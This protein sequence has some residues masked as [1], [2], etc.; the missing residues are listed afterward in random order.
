MSFATAGIAPNPADTPAD[1]TVVET[2]PL[3]FGLGE[4]TKTITLNIDNDT[5]YELTESLEVT[6]TADINGTVADSPQTV[7]ITDNLD[8]YQATLSGGAVVDE[9]AGT[10]V[11]TVALDQ[12]SP[13]GVSV[14][15]AVAGSGA[16]PADNPD[17]YTVTETSP[18]TFALGETTKSQ[19]ML[20]SE[21]SGMAKPHSQPATV[22][23]MPDGIPP[24]Q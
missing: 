23:H 2:T 4:D 8:T 3:T 16:N 21:G 15:F 1:Y 13:G 12:P 18:L 24:P 6:I 7:N 9:A 11:L 19:T 10:V 17:D 22:I 20:L 5:I 14:D